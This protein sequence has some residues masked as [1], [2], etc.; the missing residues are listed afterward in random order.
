MALSLFAMGMLLAPRLQRTIVIPP[1]GPM[2][3]PAM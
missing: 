3:A 2:P 1:T